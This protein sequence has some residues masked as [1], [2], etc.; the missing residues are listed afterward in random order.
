MH[1]IQ[2]TIE[3]K[4]PVQRVY[5]FLTQP[6]NL[7]SIWPNMVSV[8]NVVSQGGGAHSFDWVYKMA[9]VH[10]NGHASTEEVQP[11]KLVRVKNQ[12]GI[13]STFRWSYQG[14]NG[15]NTRLTVEVEYNIPG[16][17][18]GK[19]AEALVT[20]INERDMDTLLANLKDL[21]ESGAA[22]VAAGARAH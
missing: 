20:K 15:G 14:L 18:V 16:A 3:I 17:V 8:T 7:P 12:G 10:F 13:P 2:R 4:A 19:I 22:G 21:M 11:A 1:K 5:D 6:A 9:G